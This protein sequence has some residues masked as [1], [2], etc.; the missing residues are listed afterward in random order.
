MMLQGEGVGTK[1]RA[2][3]HVDFEDFNKKRDSVIGTVVYQL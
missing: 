1:V 3:V 2:L